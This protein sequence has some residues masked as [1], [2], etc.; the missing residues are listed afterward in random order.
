ML[1][2]FFWTTCGRKGLSSFSSYCKTFYFGLEVI[3]STWKSLP[4]FEKFPSFRVSLKHHLLSE[5]LFESFSP[6][7]L[8]GN[9]PHSRSPGQLQT[10]FVWIM[11]AAFTLHLEAV[12]PSFSTCLP[13]VFLLDVQPAFVKW[14]SLQRYCSCSMSQ[15]QAR[16]GTRQIGI[17]WHKKTFLFLTDF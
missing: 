8:F 2:C 13:L 16:I 15:T 1:L 10:K 3:L 11:P 14:T 9:S 5:A 12:S 17:L 6:L 4:W 7:T